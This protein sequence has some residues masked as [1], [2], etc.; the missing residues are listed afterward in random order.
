MKANI[1]TKKFHLFFLVVVFTMVTACQDL[2]ENPQSFASPNN[3]YNDPSQIEAV[4]TASMNNLWGSW[5]GYGWA[6]R[7]VFRNTDSQN[8]GDMN[9]SQNHGSDLWRRHYRSIVNINFAIKAINDGRLSGVSQAEIDVLMGQAKFL[10]AYNYFMLV[11]MFGALPMPT[12]ELDDPF[13]TLLE[14]TPVAGVYA[15]IE[16]DL[17]EAI[18]K[19]PPVWPEAQQGRPSMDVAKGLLA[20]AYLT[21]ATAPLNEV[22]NYQ[23]AA[24][25]AREVI[26]GQRYSLVQDIDEVFSLETKY[27]PEMMWSFNSNNEDVSTSPQIWSSIRGWGDISV[28]TEWLDNYPDQPRKEAYFE[29]YNSEGAYFKDLGRLAGVKKYHYGSDFDAGRAIINIPILRYADVLLIFAEAENMAKG[30]PTQAAVDAINMVIDRANG[31][32]DNP[33]HPKLTT[34]MSKEDFDT[35]VIEERNYELCFEFDRWFD[36]CRKRILGDKTRESVRQN[37]SESDYLF[38]IPENDLR[39]NPLL[40][41]NPG[42]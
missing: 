19:L 11:R 5:S 42:Y 3:F 1:Y 27:G 36:L 17:L 30:G 38:P 18:Q 4:F 20:K 41:Q 6:M 7:S 15:L 16:S 10:R 28:Q 35:A 24:T 12:E 33:A 8:G 26:D 23:K 21:M 25:L 37:F 39:L 31:Y 29:M 22:S 13:S 34:A 2:E 32:V 14:R 40:T 9:I